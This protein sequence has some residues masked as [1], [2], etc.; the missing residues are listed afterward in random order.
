MHV[1]LALQ[2]P[3]M[4]HAGMRFFPGVMSANRR[5]A[6]DAAAH[7]WRAYGLQRLNA[8][9]S[10]TLVQG[11]HVPLAL[12]PPSSSGTTVS[13]QP[14][15]SSGSS[16]SGNSAGTLQRSMSAPAVTAV[17]SSGAGA[18]AV[19]PAFPVTKPAYGAVHLCEVNACRLPPGGLYKR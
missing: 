11:N 7:E 12:P 16:G 18:A 13:L 17:S 3:A 14:A 8:F 9:D 10:Q 15:S 5:Q 2:L 19:V 6:L 1:T 4:P